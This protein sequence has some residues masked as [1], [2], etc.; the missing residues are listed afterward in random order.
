MLFLYYGQPP[1][2]RK[3]SGRIKNLTN[4]DFVANLYK[5]WFNLHL[6]FVLCFHDQVSVVGVYRGGFCE[7]LPEADTRSGR[8]NVS[9]LQD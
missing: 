5:L 2:V 4:Y 6:K 9:W 7:Q 8:A 3:G 1:H